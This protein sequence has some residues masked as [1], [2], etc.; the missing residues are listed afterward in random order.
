VVSAVAFALFNFAGDPV[1]QMVGQDATQERRAAIREALGLNDSIITQYARFVGRALQ[2]DFGLSLRTRISVT[3][4]IL[5]RLPATLELVFVSALISLIVGIAAGVYTG[6]RRTSWGARLILSGSLVGVSLPTFIIGIALIYIPP[7]S[8]ASCARKCS[9]S[10]RPI[11]SNS[12]APVACPSARSTS[13]TP[14]GLIAYS[15]ITETV[16]Q[17][18]GTGLLFIQAVE[19]ADIPV[20]AAY[21]CFVA[22]IFVLVNLI[23]DLAYVF[24][25]PRIK[26]GAG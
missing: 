10:C 3:E 1:N 22:A 6:I 21:L 4:Q 7:S 23:V 5:D 12:P 18:P 26:L 8:C 25:D 17:W 19:F 9:K 2:G 14:G 24:I 13:P 15:I 16:F 20:M 11:T